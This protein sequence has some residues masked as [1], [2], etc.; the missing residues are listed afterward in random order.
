MKTVQLFDNNLI[1]GLN[2]FTE[3]EIDGEKIP[4]VNEYE[5]PTTD[6]YHLRF[7]VNQKNSWR[8]DPYGNKAEEILPIGAFQSCNNLASIT[9]P[10]GIKRIE[11][12]AFAYSQNLSSITLPDTI[13]YIGE[14]ALSEVDNGN[15]V[16]LYFN[17]QNLKFL[18]H[19]W[20][21]DTTIGTLDDFMTYTPDGLAYMGHVLLGTQKFVGDNVTVKAGTTQI[22]ESAFEGIS[23]ITAVTLP[24]SIIEIETKAFKGTNIERIEFKGTRQQFENI[25]MSVDAF[26]HGTY[27]LVCTDGT[28]EW[29]HEGPVQ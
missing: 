2:Y 20:N 28:T 21:D 26:E 7:K 9:L 15:D 17:P 1:D 23:A 22:Y 14:Y 5:F 27:T 19:G 4:L 25:N 24:A 11:P 18:G 12:Y 8:L 3:M 13:E 10:K 6:D 16:N 29:E